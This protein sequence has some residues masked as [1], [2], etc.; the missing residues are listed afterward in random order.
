MSEASRFS[1]RVVEGASAKNDGSDLA[2]ESGD[3]TIADTMSDGDVIVAK[4][5][6]EV[7]DEIVETKN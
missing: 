4:R 1:E 2:Q 5:D 6:G 7:E 3:A